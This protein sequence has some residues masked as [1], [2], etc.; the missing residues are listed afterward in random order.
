MRLTSQF[1]EYAHG[2]ATGTTPQNGRMGAVAVSAAWDIGMAEHALAAAAALNSRLRRVC[3]SAG[4]ISCPDVPAVEQGSV[5][6]AVS[7]AGEDVCAATSECAGL[8]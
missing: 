8:L 3:V 1:A 2:G 7:C 6:W 5:G 4:S